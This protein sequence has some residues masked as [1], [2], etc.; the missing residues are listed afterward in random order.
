MKNIS[1]GAGLVVL[2]LGI[3]LHP[4]IS[5][6]VAQATAAPSSS[7]ATAAAAVAS[8][9]TAQAGPTVVWMGVTHS[10]WN[11]WVYHRLWS[12]GR[13]ETRSVAVTY[14]QP[15]W[16]NCGGYSA[17]ARQCMTPQPW[18]EVPPPPGGNGFTCRS[19]ING[20]R[21]V[22]GT[23][24]AFIL[25]SWGEEGGCEPEPTYPCLDLGNLAGGVALK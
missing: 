20:D 8:A 17:Y 15:D 21:I 14:D 16:P 1:T 11:T 25:N 4:L 3:A 19:D 6:L 18:R 2:G 9:A 7:S 22:D 23:D 24:L 5:G 10:D 12:D 13:L